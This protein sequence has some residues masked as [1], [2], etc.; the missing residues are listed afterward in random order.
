M[1]RIALSA[2]LLGALTLTACDSA[3]P[4]PDPIP[5]NVQ[6]ATNI[7]A[8]LATAFGPTGPVGRNLFTLYDLDTGTIVL[9]SDEED[10]AVRAADSTGTAWDI[11]FRSTT[12]IFNSGIS[13]PGT[14]RAQ[15]LDN[16]LFAELTEAPM[17]G[18]LQDGGNTCPAVQTPGGTFP[19]TPYVICTGSDNGWYNYNGQLNLVSPLAG[20]AIVVQTSEG[21]Y[22]KI[23]ILSY[24]EDNPAT[25]DPNTDTSRYYTF[26]YVL[27]PDGSRGFETTIPEDN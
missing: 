10:P 9:A 11:G 6:T 21:D 18:Y 3:D 20:K 15:L 25:P 14:V 4:E 12:V 2:L 7:P 13:G 19:G 5:L 22:A 8:D 27:Q 26:D 1:T 24:Y 16:T 23:R 17:D